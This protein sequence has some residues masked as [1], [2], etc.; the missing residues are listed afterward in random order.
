MLVRVP[1]LTG[2]NIAQLLLRG[3]PDARIV[4]GEYSSSLEYQN[5]LNL[6]ISTLRGGGWKFRGRDLSQTAFPLVGV[7]DTGVATTE[8]NH[9]LNA[10][11]MV[12][13]LRTTI[14]TGRQRGGR[15]KVIAP[16]TATSLT[17]M[18]WDLGETEGGSVRRDLEIFPD[19]G[20]LAV[21]TPRIVTRKVGRP[22]TGFVGKVSRR[23]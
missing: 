8:E 9:T 11:D 3:V 12:R 10:G 2:R 18:N 22:F 5:A 15:F 19:Y 17:L 14:E 20:T 7:S 6:F 4:K 21:V 23:T 1:A 16:V 13:V